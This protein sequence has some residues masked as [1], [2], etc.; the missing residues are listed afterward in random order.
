MKILEYAKTQQLGSGLPQGDTFLDL[1]KTEF[2]ET[3]Y[4]PLDGPARPTTKIKTE[5]HE[6]FVP[7]SVVSEL[8]KLAQTGKTKTRI[9]RTGT[10]KN[11]TKY[12]VVSTEK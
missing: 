8:V 6:Y 10:T 5:D 4:I 7:K 12:T 11:D 2:E 9:T 1:E 3:T